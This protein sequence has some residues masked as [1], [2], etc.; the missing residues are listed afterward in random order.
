MKRSHAL[1][2][3]AILPLLLAACSSSPAPAP[4]EALRAKAPEPPPADAWVMSVRESM[5]MAGGVAIVGRVMQGTVR[6]QTPGELVGFAAPI[7]VTVAALDQGGRAVAEVPAGQDVAALLMGIEWKQ[8]KKGHVLGKPGALTPQTT[9]TADFVLARDDENPERN[10]PTF[11]PYGIDLP[12]GVKGTFRLAKDGDPIPYAE[13]VR[14]TLTLE[15]PLVLFPGF[16]TT[17]MWGGAI[18]GDLTII[19]PAP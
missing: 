14:G 18:V 13:T 3:L 16:P 4:E 1:L 9:W 6:A 17:I 11:A 5:P 19:A 15:Q 10:L 12:S 7:P 8:V 2:P